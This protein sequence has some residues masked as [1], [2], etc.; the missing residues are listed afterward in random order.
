LETT[1][2]LV[3]SEKFKLRHTIG[4]SLFWTTVIGPLRFNFMDVLQSETF[5]KTESFELTIATRF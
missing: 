3:V 2:D 4:F 5:D 1:N